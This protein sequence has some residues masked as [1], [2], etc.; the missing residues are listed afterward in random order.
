MHTVFIKEDGADRGSMLL[1]KLLSLLCNFGLHFCKKRL[2]LMF[3]LN[4]IIILII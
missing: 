4:Q 3:F 1:S 2:R